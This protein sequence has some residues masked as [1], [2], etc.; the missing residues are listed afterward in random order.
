MT[1]A[2]ITWYKRSSFCDMGPD[3]SSCSHISRTLARVA[4]NHGLSTCITDSRWRG[5]TDSVTWIMDFI[6]CDDGLCH[7][8]YRLH[9][10]RHTR[11]LVVKTRIPYYHTCPKGS[12]PLPKH[13]NM[14]IIGSPPGKIIIKPISIGSPWKTL[15]KPIFIGSPLHLIT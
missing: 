13:S 12:P 1:P 7:V 14:I 3:C 15:A 9:I 2:C 4:C 11:S 6:T 5:I 8:Y 10:A